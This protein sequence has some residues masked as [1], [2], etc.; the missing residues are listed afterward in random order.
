[1]KNIIEFAKKAREAYIN[2]ISG[3]FSHEVCKKISDYINR[4]ESL[5]EKEEEELTNFINENTT[6][7]EHVADIQIPEDNKRS[8]KSRFNRIIPMK[9]SKPPGKIYKAKGH[10]EKIIGQN[11]VVKIRRLTKFKPKKTKTNQ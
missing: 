8:V 7:I 3:P 5:S 11:N 1:M 2:Y 6:C 4:L 9:M 10:F